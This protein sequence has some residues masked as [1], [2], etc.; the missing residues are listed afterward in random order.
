MRKPVGIYGE[1]GLGPERA[2]WR[3][4]CLNAFRRCAIF[5]VQPHGTTQLFHWL[6]RRCG[7]PRSFAASHRVS[8]HAQAAST[9][10]R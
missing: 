7:G 10:Q 1:S 4:L 5:S 9:R 2:T 3:S 6:P 8:G